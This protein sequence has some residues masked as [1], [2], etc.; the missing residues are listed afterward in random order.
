MGAV[1]Q[2]HVVDRVLRASFEYALL[3]STNSSDVGIEGNHHI[4]YIGE[5]CLNRSVFLGNAHDACRICYLGVV[6]ATVERVRESGVGGRVGREHR[7]V[8]DRRVLR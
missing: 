5:H 6:R 2:W 7:G 3:S 1:R 8:D 4:I